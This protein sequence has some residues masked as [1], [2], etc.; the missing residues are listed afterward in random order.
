MTSPC[1]CCREAAAA[2]SSH[3][4]SV[5]GVAHIWGFEDAPVSQGKLEHAYFLHGENMLSV[6]FSGSQAH[7]FKS[8]ATYDHVQ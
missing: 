2:S 4:N 8:V 1:V 7:V 3:S 5:L 6:A